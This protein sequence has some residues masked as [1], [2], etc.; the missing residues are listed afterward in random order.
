MYDQTLFSTCYKIHIYTRDMTERSDPAR[1][2]D[3]QT[4]CLCC[5][6]R[7]TNKSFPHEVI[8]EPEVRLE[9]R[10]MGQITAS[11]PQNS[12]PP[13]SEEATEIRTNRVSTF[14]RGEPS[15]SLA[16]SVLLPPRAPAWP[17]IQTR[18]P[19]AE[20]CEAPLLKSPSLEVGFWHVS[21][22]E[23]FSLSWR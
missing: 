5:L 1:A 11:N 6:A 2:S 16:D 17:E 12:T 3:R 10:R 7:I 8:R 22:A 9:P 15:S 13:R 20:E 19:G 18:A 21:R 23:L 14:L 4:G